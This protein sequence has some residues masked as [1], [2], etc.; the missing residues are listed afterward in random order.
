MVHYFKTV[1]YETNAIAIGDMID[2][3]PGY[4]EVVQIVVDPI[5]AKSN[6]YIMYSQTR[7]IFNKTVIANDIDFMI[8][9]FGIA[10]DTIEYR[11]RIFW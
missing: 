4:A 9:R 7:I 2:F 11:E 10:E 3:A 6:T 1:D 5:D 8:G